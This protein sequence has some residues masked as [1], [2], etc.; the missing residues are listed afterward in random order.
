MSRRRRRILANHPYELILRVREGLPFVAL[1]LIK[2]LIE[3]I[4][5]RAQRDNKVILCHYLWMGNHVHILLIPLNTELCVSFYQEIQKKITE[6]FKRLLGKYRLN[7]WEGEP[8]LAQILDPDKMTQ[9][10]AYLYANPAKADLVETISDYPG[11]STWDAFN[12]VGKKIDG[13]TKRL[14]PWIRLPN[15][16]VLPSLSIS[17]LED[18]LKTSIL[19]KSALLSHELELQPNAWMKAFGFKTD[20]D[21]EDY[22][23]K[24]CSSIDQME[25]NAA[26]VRTEQGKTV[27]GK[28]R[29]REQSIL[30]RHTPQKRERRIYVF[31]TLNELRIDFIRSMKEFCLECRECY[32]AWKNGNQFVSWPPGAF[33][34]MA[35]PLA[36]AIL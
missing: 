19:K 6:T 3:G 2:L 8:V 5:A 12:A 23:Q 14:V 16:K 28:R 1:D 21:A 36:T 27:V 9:R 31:T 17:R 34:P 24:I 30:K 25:M 33:R 15:I 4:L 11:L 32:L 7:L 35:P 26:L 20:L 10:I 13:S 29:L 22:F 18:T